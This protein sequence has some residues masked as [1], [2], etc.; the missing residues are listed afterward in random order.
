MKHA[1]QALA[2][3]E[4]PAPSR[5]VVI[6]AERSLG[7]TIARSKETERLR[8]KLLRSTSGLAADSSKVEVAEG[9]LE[10]PEQF[11]KAVE[12]VQITHLADSGQ[13]LMTIELLKINIIEITA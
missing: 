5:E 3:L 8:D 10:S 7:E 13:F 12:G 9:N 1:K 11:Q 4:K 6:G 2:E